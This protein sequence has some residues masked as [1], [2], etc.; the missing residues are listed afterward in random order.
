MNYIKN[1]KKETVLSIGAPISKERLICEFPNLIKE[2][3]NLWYSQAP[4]CEAIKVIRSSGITSELA[5]NILLFEICFYRRGAWTIDGK[6]TLL[7][8]HKL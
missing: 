8:D 4:I 1:D 7:N 5:T 2:I 6:L 3:N